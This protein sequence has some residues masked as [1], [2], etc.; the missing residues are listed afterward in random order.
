MSTINDLNNLFKDIADAIREKKGTSELINPKDFGIEIRG[1][2]GGDSSE[3]VIYCDIRNEETAIKNLLL[4]LS[5]VLKY[6]YD[7]GTY[8]MPLGL[9]LGTEKNGIQND[10]Q[11]AIGEVEYISL[12]LDFEICMHSNYRTVKDLIAM[13]VGDISSIPTITKEEFYSVG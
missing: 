9:Y 6:H 1:I 4:S 11:T 13:Y 10:M 12:N 5:E 2:S 7:G 3:N 8:I